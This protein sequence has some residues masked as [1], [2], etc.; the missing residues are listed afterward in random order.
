[1]TRPAE[2]DLSY[3]Q[4]DD[5]LYQFAL[6]RKEDGSPIDLT[7]AAISC[8]IRSGPADSKP[9]V[10]TA[11]CTVLDGPNGVFSMVLASAMTEDLAG[12]TYRYDIQAVINSRIRTYLKGQLVGDKEITR[13]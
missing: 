13:T 1:M 6:R 11:V 7:G 5:E 3:Y 10:A 12:K 4:G 9:I 2:H 8:Q